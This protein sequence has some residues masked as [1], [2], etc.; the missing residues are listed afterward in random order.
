[1]PDLADLLLEVLDEAPDDQEMPT[2]PEEEGANQAVVEYQRGDAWMPDGNVQPTVTAWRI[3]VTP[4]AGRDLEL[5]EADLRSV[6]TAIR[7]RDPKLSDRIARATRAS[8]RRDAAQS[9]VER[10]RGLISR[11]DRFRPVRLSHFP[12]Y[13]VIPLRRCPAHRDQWILGPGRSRILVDRGAHTIVL[14]KVLRGT[15]GR[16]NVFRK[17]LD[18]RFLPAFMRLLW[19]IR[20]TRQDD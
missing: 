9:E 14:L 16:R 7:T 5:R 2:L 6:E 3:L 1:M 12:R 17:L 19:T 15:A 10:L 8:A 18:L 13:D 4:E 20:R 11:P